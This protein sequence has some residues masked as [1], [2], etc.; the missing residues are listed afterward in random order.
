M[1]DDQVRSRCPV[2]Y[3]LDTFRFLFI[4]KAR[5]VCFFA[6][7]LLYRSLVLRLE[8]PF[9]LRSMTRFT[10]A[11]LGALFPVA[12][13]L[14]RNVLPNLKS[15]QDDL[16]SAEDRAKAVIDIFRTSWDGY[17]KFAFPHDELHP[18]TNSFS[19]SRYVADATNFRNQSTTR[20]N[21]L[22]LEMAGAP[23][24]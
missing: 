8:C 7:K 20:A 16:P 21:L 15:R 18:V 1:R 19:D 6:N 12:L 5:L 11:V 17:Y 3:I 4:V 13:G 14:P 10:F 24:Q 22:D 9:I 2:G 23:L